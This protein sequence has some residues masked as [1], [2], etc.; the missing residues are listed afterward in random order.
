VFSNIAIKLPVKQLL[1]FKTPS[2]KKTQF[3]FVGLFCRQ[4]VLKKN[5]NLCMKRFIILFALIIFT[6]SVKATTP[7]I[8]PV[9]DTITNLSLLKNKAVYKAPNGKTYRVSFE[10]DEQN[11]LTKIKTVRRKSRSVVERAAA[12]N[13]ACDNDNRFDGSYR[14]TAKTSVA[15]NNAASTNLAKLINRLVAFDNESIA[16]TGSSPRIEIEDSVVTFISVFLYAIARETDEDYHIII[17]TSANASTA[18]FLNIE[19]SGLPAPGNPAFNKI[20]A[21]RLKV[22]ALLGGM[23]RCS[24][25]YV[26]FDDHPK[27]KIIGS[28]F[29]DKEHEHT[30]PGPAGSK[31][32]TAWELHPITEFKL[33]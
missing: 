10:A 27:V 14:K 19:C 23:E 5:L 15:A 25:G 1:F 8:H 29:Y 33:L 17:G 21:A 20:K 4:P 12:A 24:G 6:V 11:R 7:S 22:V 30:I 26:K 18:K 16:V 13:I 32:K 9:Q 3:F 31:P 2:I 28:L